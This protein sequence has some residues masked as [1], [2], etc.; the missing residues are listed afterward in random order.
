MLD[1]L[2]KHLSCSHVLSPGE[3]VLVGISGG[4][5]SVVLS[6][7][8]SHLGFAL[9]LAHVN[10]GLRSR[11]SDEDARLA[12]R[13]AASLDVPFSELQPRRKTHSEASIQIWARRARY[14]WFGDLCAQFGI[15]KCAVAH[16]ADDQF[17]TILINLNRGTG[18][19]GLVGMRDSRPLG[20]SVTLIRPLLSF[21]RAELLAYANDNA[22]LWREDASNLDSRYTRNAIR[23]ELGA[24][25]ARDY[26][27]FRTAGLRLRDRVLRLEGL[28]FTDSTLNSWDLWLDELESLPDY[29]RGWLILEVLRR[30]D[31]A[32]P[33]RKSVVDIVGQLVTS[34]VGKR[35]DIGQI[36][37]WRERGKL[38]F[39]K[40]HSSEGSIKIT[41]PQ[42][43]V[44][45][46]SGRLT[47]RVI[48]RAKAR[49]Q[50]ASREEA[51][52][53]AAL[54]GSRLLIRPWKKSDRFHPLGLGGSKKVKSFLTDLKV[55]AALKKSI[56][57]VEAR[58]SVAWV[59]GCRIDE[60]F[61][62]TNNTREVVH[63]VWQ[64]KRSGA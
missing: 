8:L 12:R 60:R 2:S 39:R 36:Q 33:R 25:T 7:A 61:K 42:D 14:E 18:L 45:T 31:A 21:T 23:S 15:G 1:R 19:A 40:R 47:V 62:I 3:R 29:F 44:Q 6:R 54:L 37:V 55:P 56:L 32:A 41:L 10:Y 24:M 51:F 28:F 46:E 13:L 52:L 4:L 57:V 58:D 63:L 50:G 20:D 16:H 5:D 17:E 11:A 30:M 59:V 34:P 26:A 22:L 53:D 35:V 49:F 27:A 38:A 43:D 64:S 9:H 48:P